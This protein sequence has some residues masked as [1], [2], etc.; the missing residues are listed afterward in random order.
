MIMHSFNYWS[1]D[2]ITV[3]PFSPLWWSIWTANLYRIPYDSWNDFINPDT[4]DYCGNRNLA[5]MFGTILYW[6][7]VKGVRSTKHWWSDTHWKQQS[8]IPTD[9]CAQWG[10][11]C[12][13]QP[14]FQEHLD[15]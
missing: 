2:K 12:G 8:N 6:K 10:C 14:D 7:P 11:G 13:N 4:I 1:Y 5:R 3:E 9:Y 15:Q